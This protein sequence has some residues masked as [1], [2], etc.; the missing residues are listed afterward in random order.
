L[1]LY[2]ILG[3]ISPASEEKLELV[4][5]CKRGAVNAFALINDTKN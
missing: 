2:F 4:L 1:I 5:K 3:N